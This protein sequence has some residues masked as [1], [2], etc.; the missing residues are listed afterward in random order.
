MSLVITHKSG[1][2]SEGRYLP[3]RISTAEQETLTPKG[4]MSPALAG[5]PA[6]RPLAL[7]GSLTLLMTLSVLLP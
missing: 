7:L 5:G 2:H 3:R 6:G 4:D 1:C